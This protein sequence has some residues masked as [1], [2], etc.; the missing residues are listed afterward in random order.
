M[1]SIFRRPKIGLYYVL[2]KRNHKKM[3]RQRDAKKTT[4]RNFSNDSFTNFQYTFIDCY[5]NSFYTYVFLSSNWLTRQ[6]CWERARGVKHGTCS[7]G[8]VFF[9]LSNLMYY[10]IHEDDLIS[11]IT[12]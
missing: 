8:E 5:A 11:D 7:F 1:W 4:K 12:L 10:F 2:A 6:S 3:F 9:L